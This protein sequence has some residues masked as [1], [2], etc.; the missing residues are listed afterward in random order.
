M[1]ET[2]KN[3][4]KNWWKRAENYWIGIG[5]IVILVAVSTPFLILHRNH[6]DYSLKSF[7]A[8]GVV[9]DFFGGTTVGL[10]SLASILFVTAAIVMQK[11]ELSLQREEI[12]K[13]RNEYEITNS[14][15]KKQQFESTFFNMINLQNRI[16]ND[17]RMN[18]PKGENLQR[19][20]LKKIHERYKSIQFQYQ[21]EFISNSNQEDVD[22]LLAKMNIELEMKKYIQQKKDASSKI[23]VVYVDPS[24][25]ANLKRKESEEKK[26]REFEESVKRNEEVGWLDMLNGLNNTFTAVINDPQK[27]RL[28]LSSIDLSKSAVQSPL[29]ENFNKNYNTMPLYSLK[30]RCFEEVYEEFRNVLTHYFK[31]LKQILYLIEKEHFFDEDVRN[32]EEKKK[33]R[34][35]LG[36]QISSAEI[37]VIF[38]YTIYSK[39][40]E[41]YK[42]LLRGKEFFINELNEKEFIWSNDF[43]ELKNLN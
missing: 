43:E 23:N 5:F 13:T 24:P 38:Y 33:Y 6:S 37:L 19:V 36:A 39:E 17:M 16:I 31:N 20:V 11:E 1:S 40:G 35:I 2:K 34:Q 21:T 25:D 27:R 29:V 12:Q 9:G 10:L 41:E 22:E 3:E 15:M 42:E 14:T 30:K 26:W 18:S 8:L 7:E 28:L 4:N 32:L